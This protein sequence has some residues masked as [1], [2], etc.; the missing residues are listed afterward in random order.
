MDKLILTLRNKIQ[1]ILERSLLDI[2]HIS[3]NKFIE[4]I[5]RC[6]VIPELEGTNLPK[7]VVDYAKDRYND[8]TR[9]QFYLHYLNRNY[10][11]EGF[12]YDGATGIDDLN[13]ELM[14]YCHVWESS[15]FLKTLAHIAEL[16]SGKDYNW[17]LSAPISNVH[18]FIEEKIIYPIRKTILGELITNS[19][20]VDYRNAFAHALYSIDEKNRIIIIRNE[21]IEDTSKRHITFEEFQLKFLNS[22]ILSNT[23]TNI[24]EKY[25]IKVCSLGFTSSPMQLPSGEKVVISSFIHNVRNEAIPKFT[26]SL[27]EPYFP[28]YNVGEKV[29]RNANGKA[30]II[31]EVRSNKYYEAIKLKCLNYWYLSSLFHI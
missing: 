30:Y 15:Y 16:L 18:Q 19:Y 21:H 11:K 25:R 12:N 8:N 27:F 7:Y 26:I 1:E 17:E 20:N 24:I 28:H 5:S 13:I 14:I 22:V 6:D 29:Y 2:L 10:N 23:L 9:E 4:L 31:K 3:E